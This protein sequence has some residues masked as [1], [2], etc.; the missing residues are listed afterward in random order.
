ML[1]SRL[2]EWAGRGGGVSGCV[3]EVCRGG[4]GEVCQGVW[5]GG[6]SGCEACVGR[7]WACVRRVCW[8][9]VGIAR[10]ALLSG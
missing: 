8:A 2:K 4:V 6:K 10:S 9:R 1:H 7:A 5:R 3:G